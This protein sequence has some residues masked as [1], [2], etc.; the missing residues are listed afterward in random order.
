ML[1]ESKRSGWRTGKWRRAESNRRHSGYE[2]LALPL[3]YAAIT[4]KRLVL[5][6][7][8]LYAVSDTE[9]LSGIGSNRLLR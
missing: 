7:E 6:S 1:T 2:P 4:T 8:L 9:Q 5:G 3:S